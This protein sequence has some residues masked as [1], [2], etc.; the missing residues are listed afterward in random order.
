MHQKVGLEV[1]FVGYDPAGSGWL[2]ETPGLYPNANETHLEDDMKLAVRQ[3]F[4]WFARHNTLEE[5]I[6]ECKKPNSTGSW[7]VTD[8]G[9]GLFS[10]YV[11]SSVAPDLDTWLEFRIEPL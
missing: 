7:P 3:L 4:D 2:K 8:L 1:V 9:D 10:L 6:A 11:G 5:L